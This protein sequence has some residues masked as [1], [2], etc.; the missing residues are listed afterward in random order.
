MRK[1]FWSIGMTA[2]LALA[3]YILWRPNGVSWTRG[4]E[5]K[6]AGVKVNID[7]SSLCAGRGPY[8]RDGKITTY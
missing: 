6:R 2:V 4:T 1:L 7:N 3:T 8:G 5:S